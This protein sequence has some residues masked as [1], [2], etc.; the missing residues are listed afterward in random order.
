MLGDL[1]GK[2]G[3]LDGRGYDLTMIEKQIG[4]VRVY[5][6][7]NLST[8]PGINHFVSGRQGGVSP[9]PFD[10]L[11]LGLTVG[12]ELERVLE[13]RRRI[14]STV[15]VP[16]ENLVFPRQVH[17]ARVSVVNGR[18]RGRGAVSHATAVPDC[19]AL[20]TNERQ[21]ALIVLVAD[22]VP[23][24][25]YDP[26]KHVIGAAHAGWR[27]TAAGVTQRVVETM[28]A[29]FLSEPSDLVVGVGPAIGPGSYD[30]RPEVIQAF[31]AASPYWKELFSEGDGRV[32]LD[33]WSANRKALVESNVRASSIEVAGISTKSAVGEFFSERASRPTGRFGA[34]IML[35]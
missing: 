35:H 27:G 30:V 17:G 31:K 10:S 34:C 18:D 22:C 19:D 12:D 4:D 29:S 3:R 23:I 16:L 15:K 25:V 11:N 21:V 14:C 8:F 9:E 6:F 7:E 20:V 5:R 2:S 32:F 13:N 33:L 26:V 28:T 1:F 24:L